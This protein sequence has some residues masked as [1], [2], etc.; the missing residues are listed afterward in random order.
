[1]E[2]RWWWDY[3]QA[4]SFILVKLYFS[5]AQVGSKIVLNKIVNH[6]N[7]NSYKNLSSNSNKIECISIVRL[8]FNIIENDTSCGRHIYSCYTF[9]HTLVYNRL[10]I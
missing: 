4:E 5:V 10:H 3:V 9:Y 1:M 2:I 7:E 8:Y 6:S